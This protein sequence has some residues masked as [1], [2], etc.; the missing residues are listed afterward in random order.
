MICDCWREADGYIAE[1]VAE[2]LNNMVRQCNHS[3]SNDVILL[4][5]WEPVPSPEYAW[6]FRFFEL[7]LGS[8]EPFERLC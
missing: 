4:A 5:T 7:G 1:I 6:K 8:V 3:R 2:Q